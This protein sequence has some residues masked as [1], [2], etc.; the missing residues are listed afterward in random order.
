[1]RRDGGDGERGSP[2]GQEGRRDLPSQGPGEEG[3]VR[4]WPGPPGVGMRLDHRDQDIV[5][6]STL[7]PTNVGKEVR[8]WGWEPDT[9][10]RG[11]LVR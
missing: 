10:G 11:C 6:W 7:P 8:S 2:S 9:G 5:L 3:Q 1:M 4:T